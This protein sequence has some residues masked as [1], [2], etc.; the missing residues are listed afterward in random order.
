MD[1]VTTYWLTPVIGLAA[2]AVAYVV[3]YWR[4]AHR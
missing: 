3:A 4:A 2:L 1:E